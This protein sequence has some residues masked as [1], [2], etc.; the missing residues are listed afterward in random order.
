MYQTTVTSGAVAQ[1]LPVQAGAI[2]NF[3]SRFACFDEYRI[4]KVK[5]IVSSC[6]PANTGL[7]NCWFETQSSAT[8]TASNAKDNYTMTF[9][10]GDVNRNHVMN[11]NP[12][13]VV[14][15]GW[16]PITSVTSPCGYFKIYTDNVN[17]NSNITVVNY[18]IVSAVYWIE[19]RG[20]G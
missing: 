20:F 18:V 12:H 3:A 13:D 1:S 10:A 17:F 6:N 5:Y 2:D 9:P 14:S 16:E 4:R 19:F 11:F 15:Q 8:P 7:V